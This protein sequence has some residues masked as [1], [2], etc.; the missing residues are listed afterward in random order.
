M[1]SG[2]SEH[3]GLGGGAEFEQR[4]L[5]HEPGGRANHDWACPVLIKT[6]P[7]SVA[8]TCKRCGAVVRAP[9]GAERPRAWI[10]AS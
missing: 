7:G 10:P 9:V 4:G 3:P 1:L 6:D 2:R 8:W 5:C